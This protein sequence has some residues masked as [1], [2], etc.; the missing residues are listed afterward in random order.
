MKRF[1]KTA[2]VV[3]TAL[4]P[5]PLLVAAETADTHKFNAN[6]TAALLLFC[7]IAVMFGFALDFLAS[8]IRNAFIRQAALIL[9][10]VIA[11]GSGLT[12]LLFVKTGGFGAAELAV[13]MIM[14][15]YCCYTGAKSRRKHFSEIHSTFMLGFYTIISV[16]AE[17]FR[18]AFAPEAAN[19]KTALI[20]AFIAEYAIA[21][22]LLN[23]TNIEKQIN[24]RLDIRAL[25]P[26]NLRLFNM[27]L[28]ALV[29][30]AFA[31]IYLL[32]PVIKGAI[33]FVATSA[34]R[35]IA[36]VMSLS[37]QGVTGAQTVNV[38]P[39]DYVPPPADNPIFGIILTS[40]L[41]VM[42]M[43]ALFKLRYS[44]AALIKS[45]IRRVIALFKPRV[46]AAK[47]VAAYEDYYED[48]VFA[49]RKK[50]VARALKDYIKLYGK[51]RDPAAKM[52]LSYKI[53]LLR[54]VNG[55]KA[56]APS[57]TVEECFE[58]FGLV[59]ECDNNYRDAYCGV[60]YGGDSGEDCAELADKMVEKV[61]GLRK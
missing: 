22:L 26:K 57:D 7:A 46:S 13:F 49:K 6:R 37:P 41:T 33:V 18:G 47:P 55:G 17:L 32:G 30:A 39:A 50:R 8:K 44:V 28:I 38:Q 15:S 19:A 9:T 58:R 20:F 24:R 1:L 31:L 25:I 5:F 45:A 3:G 16:A 27:S 43:F 54:L 11:V 61:S 60:R 56:F 34:A 23:Q 29:A 21:A 14:L 48:V 42:A 35:F 2:A 51:E 53:L 4:I 36:A 59:E 12:A 10:R 52:R 40:L